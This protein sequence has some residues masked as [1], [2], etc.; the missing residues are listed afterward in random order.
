MSV[1]TGLLLALAGTFIGWFAHA[2]VRDPLAEFL[3]L[4]RKGMRSLLKHEE[5]AIK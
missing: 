4:R 5:H 3:N 2:F 1:V